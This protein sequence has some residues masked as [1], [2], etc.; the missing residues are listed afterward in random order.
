M[1]YLYN[2][3]RIL[4]QVQGTTHQGRKYAFKRYTLNCNGIQHN[5]AYTLRLDNLPN[6]HHSHFLLF[7][8]SFFFQLPHWKRRSHRGRGGTIQSTWDRRKVGEDVCLDSSLF[9]L[10]LWVGYREQMWS[11]DMFWQSQS[12]RNVPFTLPQLPGFIEGVSLLSKLAFEVSTKEKGPDA[13][14]AG[15]NRSWVEVPAR[16]ERI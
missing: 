14:T 4:L 11:C 12:L 8:P 13:N 15:Q 2:G 5:I 7:L 16:S 9:S 3:Y 1:T 10:L 6:F